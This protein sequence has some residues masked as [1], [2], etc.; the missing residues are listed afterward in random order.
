M[1]AGPSSPA[2]ILHETL[3]EVLRRLNQA[4]ERGGEAP[5]LEYAELER[6]MRSF[7]AALAGETDFRFALGLLRENGLV[8]TVDAP[9]YAW[10]RQRVVGERFR[11]TTLGKAYLTRQIQ[12]SGRI[13]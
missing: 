4:Y 6:S 12:E 5:E 9:V 2:W 10:A 1:S 3:L 7:W 13:A 8:E 11:I